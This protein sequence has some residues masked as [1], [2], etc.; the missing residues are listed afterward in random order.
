[1]NIKSNKR[2]IEIKIYPTESTIFFQYEI[3]LTIRY[4]FLSEWKTNH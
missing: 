4:P 1:M 3:P 2:S